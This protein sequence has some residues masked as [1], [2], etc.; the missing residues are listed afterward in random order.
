V[1]AF[2]STN[3]ICQGQSVPILWPILFETGCDIR[4]AYTSFRWANLASNNA[5]VTVVVIGIGSARTELHRLYETREDGTV[6]LREGASI[7]PYLT[8]GPRIIVEKRKEPARE[9]SVMEFGNK[10]TDGGYLLLSNDEATSLGLT[11]VQRER[12]LRRVYGGQDFINGGTRYCLWIE[13]EHLEEARSIGPIRERI[14]AVRRVRLASPDKGANALAK[15]AHQLKLMRIG[16]VQ[17][18]VIPRISSERRLYLPVGIVDRRTALTD[19]AFALYDA[20]LWNMA[21]IASRLHLVW[22]STVCGKMKTDFRYSNTMGWN[23]FP[24]PTLTEQNMADLTACAKDILLAREA[25]FPATIADLY[26]PEAMPGNLRDAHERNDEV[27]ERIYIGR[28]FKNDTERLEKLF[29]LYSKMTAGQ[30][31][32]KIGTKAK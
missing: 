30:T 29:D 20:P 18:I 22:I 10:P 31:K 6:V 27:L 5:G 8:I 23:T 32:S 1:A 7:T 26:E 3:S 2:V 25:H 24:V 19:L 4:F 28:R 11:I 13:D 17:T 15:R 16:K 21:I 9:L 14:E 12:F